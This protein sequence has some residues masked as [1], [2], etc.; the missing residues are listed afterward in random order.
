MNLMIL[1]RSFD[2]AND[3]GHDRS[4]L[5]NESSGS[6]AVDL[7]ALSDRLDSQRRAIALGAGRPHKIVLACQ[8]GADG[9]H[10]DAL[11]GRDVVGRATA[12]A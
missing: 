7:R 2:W 9:P 11:A 6:T 1:A 5:P 3:L 8:G 10:P 12:C 4:G